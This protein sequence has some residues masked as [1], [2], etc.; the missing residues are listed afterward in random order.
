MVE[1]SELVADLKRRAQSASQGWRPGA[2]VLSVEPLT[3]GTSSLTFT[4]RFEG[5]PDV[6]EVVVLKV[7]PPGLPPLRNRDVLR[8]G[9][10]MRAL[11]G[12]PG[13][14]VPEVL[15]EDEGRPPEVPPFLAMNL[16]PG[17]CLEPI[18]VR[19]PDLS[20]SGQYHQRAFDAARR[21]AAM[22]RLDPGS[23]GLGA[24]PVVS[25]KE[26]IDRWTRAYETVPAHLQFNYP[27]VAEALYGSIPAAVRP[28]V[29]HGD[30]R[31]GN[32]LCLDDRVTAVIDW[33]IWSVGDPRVD[34][35]WLT[36]FCDDAGHP[37]KASDQ[38]SGMPS[39]DEV[40]AA[41]F[42]AGGDEHSDLDW[43]DALTYFKEAAMTALLIKR[44][45]KNADPTISDGLVA[46]I[47]KL[48]H[49]LDMA[50]SKLAGKP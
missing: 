38:P 20:R 44:A 15:F 1:M 45:A 42:A 6:D 8:Q 3:G 41:Y 29:N 10:L 28:V 22:H 26:E 36:F 43:F 27:E 34:L 16:V 14:V 11:S 33:E 50:T 30:Y 18:L 9:V 7:A 24:E 40:R 23:I 37:S 32:A 47:P 2:R 4:T 5:V 35:T 25:I 12:R 21:L 46:F 17:E 49:L 13:V 48:G 31:L 39:S 19:E